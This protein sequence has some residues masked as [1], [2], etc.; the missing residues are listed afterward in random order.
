[1]RR[2]SHHGK[3]DVQ[4][5]KRQDEQDNFGVAGF[6]CILPILPPKAILH[7]LFFFR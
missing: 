1:M 6:S 3:Q 5:R 4:D 7:I 2:F